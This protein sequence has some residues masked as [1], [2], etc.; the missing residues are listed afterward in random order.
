MPNQDG[1][2]WTTATFG[3]E[4]HWTKEL[5]INTIS[6]IARK[7]LGHDEEVPIDVTFHAKGAFNKLYKV[8]TLGSNCL[9][10]VSLPVNPH[11][12][13]ESEVATIGFVRNETDLP[14]PRIIAFDSDNQN[15]LGFEW[16]LMELMPGVP[17]KKRWRRMSWESK[18]EIIRRL[19]K[20]QAQLFEKRFAGIGNLFIQ[21]HGVTEAHWEGHTLA[22]PFILG[23]IVSLIFFWG[24][25][26]THDVPR[27][28][29]KTSHE[30]LRTRLQ[31]VLID[32]ERILRTS[33]DEDD[34]EDAEFAKDLAERMLQVLPTVFS[35]DTSRIELSILFPDDLSM[36]NILVDENSE[37]T[38]VVDWECVSMMPPWRACQLPQL[39]EGR[40][41]DEKPDKANYA[42]ETD[43]GGQDCVISDA[44]DNEGINIL[45][46][47]HLL[48]YE[49]TQLR[50]LF[51]DEMERL[52]PEW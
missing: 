9:M 38:A 44:S 14:V 27:G 51:V 1:L 17:L 11:H 29:F 52:R 31:F 20:Y 47:E 12:K 19:V 34:I 26:L 21:H 49:Q 4:P 3:L 10:R 50:K 36:Q 30:W 33:D 8:S 37:M 18:E 22:R 39:L 35:P 48:E 43:D 40:P 7:Y 24:D 23:R 28:P 5:D 25:H 42:P 16:I 32:Q 46:W 41:R 2:K 6:R 13:T 45:Y 15:K